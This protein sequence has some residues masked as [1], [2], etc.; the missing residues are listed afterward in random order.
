MIWSVAMPGFAIKDNAGGNFIADNWLYIPASKSSTN[1]LDL[2]DN[3][4]NCDNDTWFNDVFLTAS[5]ANCMH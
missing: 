5:P 3:N 1:G 4:A 2:Q